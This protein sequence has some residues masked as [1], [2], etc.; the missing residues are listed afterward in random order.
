[1]GEPTDG[2]RRLDTIV[3]QVAGHMVADVCSIYVKRFDGSLELFATEGLN[4]EAVH[5]TFMKR[6]EG[7]VG[8]CAEL[9][10][11]V[12]E[13]DAQNHPSFS[14]RPETGEEVYHSLLAVPVKRGGDVLGV[15][16]VQNKAAREYLED[17]VEVLETTAMV[18][19]EH[20][21][22]GEVAGVNTAAEFSRTRPHTVRGQSIAEGLALGHVVLHESAVVVVDLVSDN[23]EEE[24]RRLESAVEELKQTL[25]ELVEQVDLG[26]GGEHRDVFEAYRMFAH[27]RGW[28]KRMRDAIKHGMTAEAAVARVQNDTRS[29][30]M[31]HTDPYL[32]ERLKDLDELSERLLRVLQ[33]RST[34]I[35]TKR[36]LPVDAVIVARSLGPADLLDYDRARVKGVVIED[37]SGSSHV[38]I[39][40]KAMGI[41]AV[42]QV[43]GVMERVD[44]G[45]PI[46]VDAQ[47]GDVHIRPGSD[48]IS[49]Y[50]DKARFQARKQ[51]KYRALKDVKSVTKDGHPI[52]LS[53]NA[54]LLVD[55]PQLHDAGADGIGL[56]RTELQFM[57]SR[58][59]PRL[60]RQTQMY[61]AILDDAG[62][63]PVTFRL[64]DV[65]GDKALPYL[66]QPHEENPAMGWRAIRMSLDRKGL[67]VTQVRALLRASPGRELRILMPM[68]T[69]VMEID[70]ARAV[71]DREI[72]LLRRRGGPAPKKILVGIMLEVP[73]LLFQLDQVMPKVD[74]VSVGSNDLMQ[75]LNAADRNNDKVAQRYDVLS[76][77]SLKVLDVIV[78]AAAKHKTP[79]TLCGEMAG[80]PLEAMALLGLGYRSL[81]MAASA[82]GPVKAMILAL[83][84]AAAEKRV[85]Q[86]LDA[87]T[88]NLRDPLKAFADTAGIEV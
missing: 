59:L 84:V 49:S 50:S 80:R 2:Q 67:L 16:V 19:A 42:G 38:A 6:G 56:F 26:G 41:A 48:V 82:V 28:L 77:P 60:E 75:Y 87:G 55:V 85:R 63:K 53:I 66:R 13:A 15:L 9:A 70:A 69:T 62:E 61:R 35:G 5:N 23:P 36:H 79:V 4:A 12:N 1:M 18:L 29:R 72:E 30:M 21:V 7:L 27:D 32:R 34:A 65:G 40:A 78:Q 33:G 64:L 88:Y 43:R 37:S 20:L 76:L 47:S 39:V 3:K 83:D 73:A 31:A 11:P 10:Q 81:S 58:T 57:V 46:I 24:T 22:S 54:G 68:V 17:D 8:R 74:F 86:L 45:D 25:D 44:A 51:R 71:I 52:S 14:Y